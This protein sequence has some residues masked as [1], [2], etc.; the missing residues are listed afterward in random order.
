MVRLSQLRQCLRDPAAF[1]RQFGSDPNV[2]SARQTL[3]LSVLD[4]FSRSFSSHD[5][6]EAAACFV[7]GRVEVLGKHTDYAGGRSLLAATDRG[8][9]CVTAPNGT[10]KVRLVETDPAFAPCEFE[11]SPRL[12]PVVGHWS[13][14]PMTMTR[15]L[16]SNFA[17]V[18][19]GGRGGVDVAFGC[20][21]PVAAGLSGSSAL[22]IMMFFA[23][24]L[25]NRLMESNL[26]QRNIRTQLDLAMCLAC[27][28]NGQT[29]HELEGGAGVGTFGGSE[30]HTQILNAKPGMLSLYRFCPTEHEQDIAFPDH[31][32]LVIAHS[33]VPAQK[34]GAAMESYNLASRR[35]QMTVARYNESC[36]T[37]H[38]LLR[39]LVEDQ[40]ADEQAMLA[41]T[42]AALGPETKENGLGLFARFLQFYR[43]DRQLIPGAALALRDR[44]YRGLGDIIDLS[45]TLSRIC[46]RNVIPET[47]Y[48]QRSARL[49]GA[50]A[51]SAFG[52]GFGGS[53]YALVRNDDG[54]FVRRW[55]DSYVRRFPDR[56]GAAQFFVSA[57]SGRAG[58]LLPAGHGDNS[59]RPG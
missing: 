59:Q 48:L 47:D 32:A 45:H 50:T 14:Y 26:Y 24:A 40:E 22:M 23:L 16:A 42:E 52:A 11:I 34:T 30:D 33:G 3:A 51:A 36:G 41:R 20:D 44:D 9:F 10:N 21:L 39:D 46:L 1:T 49:L 58:E 15:R 37:S 28:E 57:V 5:N 18:L 29:F 12:T 8:F 2:I 55:R 35:A 38:R 7:P 53:V 56:T 13:N 4:T 27:V 43:E 19:G 6:L 54:D 25:P 17:D 31:L